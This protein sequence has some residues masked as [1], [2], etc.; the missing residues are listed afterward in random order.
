[1]SVV[2]E[3][4]GTRSLVRLMVDDHK[5]IMSEWRGSPDTRSSCA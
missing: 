1:V 3:V 2:V 4:L 5:I